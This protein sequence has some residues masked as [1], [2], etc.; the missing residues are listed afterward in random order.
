MSQKRMITG[1][2]QSGAR[3]P[4]SPGRTKLFRIDDGYVVLVT[5]HDVERLASAANDW[6]GHRLTLVIEAGQDRACRVIDSVGA[7]AAVHRIVLCE[8]D[9]AVLARRTA[10]PMLET[11]LIGVNRKCQMIAGGSRALRHCID[12]MSESDIIVYCADDLGDAVGIL[13]D[14]GAASAA[15][16]AAPPKPPNARAPH[17]LQAAARR[18][19]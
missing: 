7:R 17:V 3:A 10:G 13:A 9:D 11:R 19:A 1:T 12:A 6:A 18:M 2:L 15:R 16:I 4:A 8:R 14:Y 5:P